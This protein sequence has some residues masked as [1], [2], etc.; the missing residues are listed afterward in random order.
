MNIIRLVAISAIVLI[1]L[2]LGAMAASS[3]GRVE[4]KLTKNT[5]FQ[6][7]GMDSPHSV[8]NFSSWPGYTSFVHNNCYH[9]HGEYK[10]RDSST[11]REISTAGVSVPLYCKGAWKYVSKAFKGVS[12]EIGVGAATFGRYILPYMGVIN[13][14]WF[15]KIQCAL[16]PNECYSYESY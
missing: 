5:F 4:I 3:P 2:S 8:K 14:S 6:I 10:V 7:R 15:T 12:S 13:F 11:G 9:V 16:K 1:V